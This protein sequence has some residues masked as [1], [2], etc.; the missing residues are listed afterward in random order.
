MLVLKG[1]KKDYPAGSGVVHALRGIDLQFRKSDFVAIL[2]PSGCGKTT[3][4]NIVGGLDGYT[5]GD[6]IINGTSTKQYKDRDWDT[7]RNHSIGFV[8]QSYNLI[9]HQTVLQ[10]VELA[11]TLAGVSK[12]ERK[13]RAKA[14]LEEVGL[15]DQ[16]YKRPSE[17]SG[18]QMQRVAIARALVNNP[19]IILADE[20]TG[21]LDTE[22]SVQ[23]MEILKR[24]SQ[25]RLVIMVTHNPDLANEY[26]TRIINML[27]GH[28]LKDSAPLSDEE[29]AAEDRRV[30]ELLAAEKAVKKK[31]KQPSMSFGTSFMLSL[32]N[33]FTKKGRTALTS[34]AGSIGIIGIALIL[35]VSQGTTAYIDYVQET[36]L[37]SYPLTIQEQTR[38]FS[39]MMSAMTEVQESTEAERDPNLIY[40]DDSMGTMMGAM[41]ATTKNN[42]EKFKA[43]I[44]ANY[45]SLKTHLSGIQYTYDFD[46]Q[47]FTADGK[48]Q[49]SPTTIFDNMGSAFSSITE[50]MDASG[51]SGM[52]SIMSE[53]IDNQALLERQ[54]DVVAG[55]W[56]DE[57]NEIV[58]VISKDN[59]I[60]KMALYML[61]IL[62][63]GELE[64]IMKNLMQN[65]EY[66]TTP[67]EPFEFEDFL[68]MSF[69]LLNTSDFYEATNRTYTVNG[70]EYPIWRDLRN[71][72]LTYD[73]PTFV[74]E[75][76]IELKISGIIRP[77][78][79]T[80]ATAITTNVAYTKA[81]TDLILDMNTKSEV[82]RQQKETPEHNVL[83][84]LEFERTVYTPE[85][86]GDLVSKIDDATMEQFYAI[87]TQEI[88]DNPEYNEM[89]KVKDA[90]SFVQFY[91]LM[92]GEQQ[93]ALMTK[94]L[95]AAQASGADMTALLATLNSMNPTIEITQDNLIALLPSLGLETEY[96]A[97]MG[98]SAEQV[99][100]AQNTTVKDLAAAMGLPVE[101]VTQMLTVPGLIDLA[102]E[103]VMNAIYEGM[104]EEILN[105]TVNEDVF[106]AILGTMN[107]E[108]E[109]FK[110]L[111]ETLYSMAPEIDATLDS[112]LKL[113]G[114]AEKAKPAS[115][116]FYP[117]DFESKD[118][119]VKFIDDYN[120]AAEE[121]DKLKYTDMMGLLMSS[122]TTIINAITYV[123]IA[124][125]SISLIV[126]SIMIG[127]I[128]LISVQERTKEIG[129]LRAIGA[130]KRNVSS[131][132]N[133]ETMIIGFTSGLLGVVVTYLLCIPINLILNALTG[134]A[135]LKAV[136]P[137]GAAIILIVI[138][139]LLTLF[140]G[141]IPSRSAAKKDPVVALRTE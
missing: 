75:H 60:S 138:S 69:R 101:Q 95:Q 1:I 13:Q 56:P 47:V 83:T 40:V 45:D 27:D 119:I 110:T 103:N 98:M 134:I 88:I 43:H 11:L 65:G 117:I 84:G 90:M 128:T 127:V 2:G 19:E 111:E 86:I 91:M 82:I 113:L 66:D 32:K 55:E 44:D 107:A 31:K 15:G 68:G 116:N 39:A 18:G 85:T 80:S 61:G 76:G 96:V 63:Q 140:A 93:S 71:D 52:M 33:L 54:Y 67:I 74:N 122:V 124:F 109:T 108:D 49:V 121:T 37:S 17:M 139:V 94:I 137:L 73:Q 70:T 6:L 105:M 42:L 77:A 129:I 72:A 34:F 16:L 133:A 132:F 36:T 35:S 125:V 114:D 22:T 21:A 5:E 106:L 3:L 8:F 115:I 81:L 53:M 120:D 89:L 24:I 118:A 135:Q 48:T 9:P 28:I 87:M 4:L 97:L 62:D 20:P 126:S 141:I 51:M 30:A 29:I 26:A 58:L 112:N 102:G 57:A 130:S 46:L 131:M 7:Y 50:L 25:N 41:S 64:E 23:V 136:L 14:A 123:L 100:Q 99:A 104:T 59:Q 10:N 79:G 38:D 92:S 78:K 12:S